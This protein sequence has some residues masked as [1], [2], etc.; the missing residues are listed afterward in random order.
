M[1]SEIRPEWWWNEHHPFSASTTRISAMKVNQKLFA[2]V[3]VNRELLFT[4]WCKSGSTP[5]WTNAGA[6]SFSHATVIVQLSLSATQGFF[7]LDRHE[8]AELELQGHR[9]LSDLLMKNLNIYLTTSAVCC[10]SL[11][12]FYLRGLSVNSIFASSWISAAGCK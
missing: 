7:L 11:F 4:R 2:A 5:G 1:K 10:L 12:I 8:N 9:R 3:L 6:H